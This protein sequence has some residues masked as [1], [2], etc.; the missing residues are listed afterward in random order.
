MP[1]DS[2]NRIKPG[3]HVHFIGIG[4]IS[5][6]GLAEILKD[7][8]YIIT[9]SDINNSSIISKLKNK[10]IKI[11]IEHKKENV[12][13]ADLVV[14]TA[15][16]NGANPEIRAAKE[17]EIPIVERSVL[18]G[19]I[20]KNYRNS[21]AVAG[22][23]GKTTTTS[24][25]SG[26]FIQASTDPTVL[27]GG[28]LDAIGGNVRIGK[29]SYFITEACEYVE[30]FLK[31]NPYVGIILN[32]EEDHL[33][34]FKDIKH[35]IRSFRE[36]GKLIQPDGYL[37]VS[38]DHI[39]V[40][41]A[42][43]SLK[44]NILS[45]GINNNDLLFRAENVSFDSMGNPKF[46]VIYKN[47]NLCKI[48]LNVPGTHNIYNSLAAV[49]CAYSLNIPVEH[50]VKGLFNFKGTHRRFE[51]KGSFN[52]ITIIDDY[53]HHPTEIKA[54]LETVNKIPHNRIWCVFQPHTY[55]RT[56]ALLNE[57]SEA[58]NA[59]DKIII[60]DIYAAREK[61]DGKIHSMDLVKKINEK[62]YEAQYISDFKDIS[63]Y[64]LNNAV[65]GDIIITMGAGDI[66]KLGEDMLQTGKDLVG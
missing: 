42:V 3:S 18:L 9:G 52:G 15:A 46:D 13:N 25:I 7:Q 64:L 50:I 53:A 28:E 22:S 39:N 11:Y 5:M 20:M 35:I 30:S 33:D 49:V 36:F 56:L 54:T 26:I 37:V 40:K 63:S 51:T 44:C 1:N 34:Y 2:F 47:K 60:T 57:F 65:A 55:T 32:I 62:S 4:G 41:K 45:Y 6:S 27:V 8:G 23:H 59:A 12:K 21:I 10:D 48:T 43:K 24:M 38:G 14:Y 31:F 66:F 61:D 16:V 29:S 58:F 19:E 17:L